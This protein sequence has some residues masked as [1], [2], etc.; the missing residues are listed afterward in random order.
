MASCAFGN[1]DASTLPSSSSSSQS[2]SYSPKPPVVSRDESLTAT[3]PIPVR[4]EAA[5]NTNRR[6]VAPADYAYKAQTTWGMHIYLCDHHFHFPAQ[7]VGDFTLRGQ[8]VVTSVAF[9]PPVRAFIFIAHRF[10]IPT[11][12]LFSSNNVANSLTLSGFSI[13]VFYARNS[14]YEDALGETRTHEIGHRDHLPSHRGRRYLYMLAQERARGNCKKKIKN[15][16][17]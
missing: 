2:S 12:C 13:I 8:A 10:R 4:H 9:F 16:A 15:R 3:S 11:A 6:A 17:A 5:V 1:G 7:L 14:P